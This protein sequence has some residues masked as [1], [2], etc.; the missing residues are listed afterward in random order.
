MVKS[1]K[2]I[3]CYIEKPASEFYKQARM[4]DG[5]FNMCKVCE[6]ARQMSYRERTEYQ[7]RKKYESWHE[8]TPERKRQQRD[9]AKRMMEKYPEKQKARSM[10][11]QAVKKGILKREPCQ[12][13]NKE[14]SEGHHP[15]YSKPLEVMWL[16]KKHHVEEHSKIKQL[17]L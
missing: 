5:L 10:V 3:K 9:I 15:D 7:S 16:C 2:C 14:K 11:S 6:Y 4:K 1:K 13:C 8:K 17:V 12:V